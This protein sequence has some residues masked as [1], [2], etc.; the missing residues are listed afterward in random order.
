[1]PV[2]TAARIYV[3]G[4]DDSTSIYGPIG[5]T[6]KSFAARSI[7][8]AVVMPNGEIARKAG[9]SDANRATRVIPEVAVAW[10]VHDGQAALERHEQDKHWND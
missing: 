3:T 7:T 1:M 8:A 2:A 9:I 10:A 4:Y 5:T 6:A